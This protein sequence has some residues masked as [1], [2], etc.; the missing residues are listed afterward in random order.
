MDKDLTSYK[1]LSK[2]HEDDFYQLSL[3]LADYLTLN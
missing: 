3:L 2:K 1:I